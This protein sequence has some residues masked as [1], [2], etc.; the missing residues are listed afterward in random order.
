MEYAVGRLY[1]QKYF[2]SKA[3][4]DVNTFN[5]I[6]FINFNQ[7]SNKQINIQ[8]ISMINNLQHEF[9][10]ILNETDWMDEFSKRIALEKVNY[11]VS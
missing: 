5:K 3:K 7:N 9:R 8:T 11:M 6:F 4:D 2:D 10:M 1:V